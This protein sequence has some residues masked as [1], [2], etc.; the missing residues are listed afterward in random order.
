MMTRTRTCSGCKQSGHRIDYCPDRVANP[1]PIDDAAR[2]RER[3]DA[4]SGSVAEHEA[5]RQ[6]LSQIIASELVELESARRELA[7]ARRRRRP[8]VKS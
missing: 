2:I 1:D 7:E 5:V 4:L 8:A 3:I 6:R